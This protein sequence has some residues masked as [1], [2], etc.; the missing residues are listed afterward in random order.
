MFN[1]TFN[2]YSFN[3]REGRLCVNEAPAIKE[4]MIKMGECGNT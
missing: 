2:K 1:F 4:E 3:V